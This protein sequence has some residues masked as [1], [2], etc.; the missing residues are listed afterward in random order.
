MAQDYQELQLGFDRTQLYK[1]FIQP[2]IN[3]TAALRAVLDFC[4]INQIRLSTKEMM[5]M[6]MR[7]QQFIE[8][9]DRSWA[10]AVDKY[11]AD[12]YEE[13]NI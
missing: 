12:K 1:E 2:Q 7:Y 8:T 6:V 13:Y 5:R 4:K 9:G 10:E 11:I 3:R